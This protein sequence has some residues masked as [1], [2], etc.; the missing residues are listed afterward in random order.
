MTFRLSA[1]SKGIGAALTH[2][3]EILSGYGLKR[4]DVIKK[5][6]AAEEVMTVLLDHA[7]K[8]RDIRLSIRRLLGDITIEISV[9]GEEFP[10][11]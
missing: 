4:R 7:E 6:L 1:D 11:E 5:M 9:A 8:A 3:E 10:F 2:I